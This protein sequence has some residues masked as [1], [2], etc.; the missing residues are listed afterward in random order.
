MNCFPLIVFLTC[1]Y[2]CSLS[3]LTVPCIG[4]WFLTVAFPGHA[5][6]LQ[7][8]INMFLPLTSYK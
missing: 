6:F 5:N 1:D 4:L 8:I 7:L 2:L 3:L